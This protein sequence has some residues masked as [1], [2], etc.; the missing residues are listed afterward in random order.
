MTYNNVN[1]T[2]LNPNR[3]SLHNNEDSFKYKL[4]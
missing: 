2:L 1:A 4:D 3:L